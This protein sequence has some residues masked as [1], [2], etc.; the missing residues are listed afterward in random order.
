MRKFLAVLFMSV[1]IASYAQVQR[2]VDGSS[3]MREQIMLTQEFNFFRD[4]NDVA[5]FESGIGESVQVFP[6]KYESADGKVQ[7]HGLQMYAFIKPEG[8]AFKIS[9]NLSGLGKFGKGMVQRSIFIDKDDV[10]RMITF[11]ER[12]IVPNL[13]KSFKKQSKEYVY[14]CREMFF[15]FL[16]DEKEL[17]ITMHLSDYGPY[18]DG[19]GSTGEQVEFW[20]ES[21]VDEIPEFLKSIK[22]AYSKMK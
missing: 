7:L 17:R 8:T 3:I 22:D 15:S 4:W 21:Q 14:K 5:K 18:G 2:A 12:D 19:R 13:N 6:V 16:I 9:T 1:S 11:I 20:T 10:A